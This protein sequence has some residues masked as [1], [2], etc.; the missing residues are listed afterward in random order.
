MDVLY[1]LMSATGSR[2]L[3]CCR[4]SGKDCRNEWNKK[5]AGN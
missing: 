5:E 3:N 2:G 4:A 1:D